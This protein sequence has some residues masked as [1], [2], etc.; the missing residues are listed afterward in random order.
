MPLPAPRACSEIRF[1]A[2]YC[3]QAATS[4]VDARPHHAQRP[5]L[6]DAAVAGEEL[7]EQIVAAHIAGNQ[8]AK[9]FLD[10]LALVIEFGHG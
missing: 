8:P 3:T 9:V 7:A 10:S 2:A 4:A 1:S 6:V 5:D